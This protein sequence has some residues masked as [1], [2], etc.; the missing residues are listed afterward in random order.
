MS[1]DYCR[2]MI[3][4]YSNVINQLNSGHSKFENS[5]NALI[6]GSQLLESVIV[7]REPLDTGKLE[8]I[9][10]IIG[11]CW[12]NLC[13]IVAECNEKIAYWQDELRK[14]LAREAAEAAIKKNNVN[15][16]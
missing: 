15:N 1:S 2:Q 14:A 3:I 9:S 5:A 7:N 6:S 8:D 16:N 4:K 11:K 10:G 12:S 13:I